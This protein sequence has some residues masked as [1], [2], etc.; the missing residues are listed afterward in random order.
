MNTDSIEIVEY[1]SQNNVTKA[2]VEIFKPLDDNE[3]MS[4]PRVILIDGAP[5]I[6]KT[7]L[8]KEIAYQ[9]SQ[10]QILT[11]KRFLFL[12]RAHEQSVQ[13]LKEV[14]DLI[15]YCCHLECEESI[16]D[17]YKCIK[18]KEGANLIVLLDGYN[19]F[20]I[21]LP[22]DCLIYQLISHQRLSKCDIVI[23]SRSFTYGPVCKFV[24]CRIEIIGFTYNDRQKYIQRALAN[25]PDDILT[26][27]NYLDSHPTFSSLCYIP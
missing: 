13:Q 18:E 23:A 17:I 6:G 25:K 21:K 8:C 16:D 4:S 20:S 14:K 12:L 22:G 7:Y 11:E 27:T 3:G 2:I 10:G 26:L 15:K 9:W 1:L 5:G 19:E 24:K